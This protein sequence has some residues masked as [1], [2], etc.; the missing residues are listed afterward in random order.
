MTPWPR[1]CLLAA[2]VAVV[3]ACTTA[4]VEPLPPPKKVPATTTTTVVD[5]SAIPLPSVVGRTTTTVAL[6][7]GK[8]S[9]SGTLLGPDGPVPGGVVRVE[10]LVG[11]GKASIDVTTG[12]DGR[13]SVPK[14][15]GGRYRVRGWK[16]APDNLALLE[17]AVFF[18]EGSEQRVVD[19]TVTRYQGLAVSAAI[20]PDPPVVGAASNLVV[21]LVDQAVDA[22]GIVRGTPLVGTPAEL[23]GS[24]DWRVLSPNPAF[25]DGS[26]RLRWLLE[27]RRV[28]HQPISVVVAGSGPVHRALPASGAPPPGGAPAAASPPAGPGARPASPT[29][30]PAS[31]TT[32]AATT[33]TARAA[34]TSTTSRPATTTTAKR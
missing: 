26:G 20:A 22:S 28:G 29:T 32:R 25:A 3:G 33:T 21:Q 10:R 5:F 6:G 11:G 1:L 34:T 27:C 14:I 7:P 17:P 31:P 18:L 23:T 16:P 8:A 24:G 12:A 4:E 13:Y 9:V 15:L 19:L 2:L 30:R